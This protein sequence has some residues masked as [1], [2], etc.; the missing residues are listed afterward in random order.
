MLSELKIIYKDRLN[1]IIED[2][3]H[4]PIWNLGKAQRQVIANL[5]YNV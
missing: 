3:L 2:A 4:Y 5:P 1:I